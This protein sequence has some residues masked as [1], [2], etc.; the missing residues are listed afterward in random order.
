MS[1]DHPLDYLPLWAVF[2]CTVVLTYLAVEAG[3]RLGT[4]RQRRAER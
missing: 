4:W 3:F 1:A 2:G